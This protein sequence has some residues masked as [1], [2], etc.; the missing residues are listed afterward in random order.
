[1]VRAKLV[2]S[3]W[4]GNY[5]QNVS[6]E[7]SIVLAASKAE[8]WYLRQHPTVL[9]L[10]WKQGVKRP[11]KANAIDLYLRDDLTLAEEKAWEQFFEHV[12]QRL[13]PQ[14]KQEWLKDLSGVTLGS[15]SYISFR[16]TIDC[17]SRYG[18]AYVVQPG[19]SVRDEDVINACNDY[20][21][22]MAFSGS[23][24]FHH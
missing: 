7:T 15:D 11:D 16:D 4:R 1:M 19:G 10:L 8:N 23:R 18:V 21:M 6:R 17:A 24:L 12:P 22:L 14:E 20:N 13:S 3:Q 2:L 5:A 9:S